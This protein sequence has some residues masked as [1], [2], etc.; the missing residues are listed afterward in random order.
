MDKK[1][2]SAKKNQSA[3]SDQL[4]VSSKVDSIMKKMFLCDIST[5][6]MLVESRSGDGMSFK[7]KAR[8]SDR[9]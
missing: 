7:G 6:L 4:D 8:L 5:R 1:E 3:P 2:N 9:R